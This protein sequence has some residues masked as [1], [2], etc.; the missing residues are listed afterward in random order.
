MKLWTGAGIGL[1]LTWIMVRGPSLNGLA[2]EV[3][4]GL[5]VGFGTAL[6]FR[7]TLKGKFSFRRSPEKFA[8]A[9]KYLVIFLKELLI[10]N[11][12]MAKRVLHPEAPISPEVIRYD[13]EIHNSL[14]ITILAN[15]ITLTPGTLTIDHHRKKN[16]LKVHAINGRNNSDEVKDTI[17]SWEKLLKKIFN[18]DQR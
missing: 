6:L 2:G 18:G 8:L 10:S 17:R 14:A 1:T 7:Q 16:E 11:L 4:N 5:V 9:I 15:S 3:L 13:L 12:D